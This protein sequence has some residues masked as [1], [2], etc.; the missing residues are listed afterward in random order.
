MNLPIR[1]RLTLAFA[2]AMAVVLA[3]FGWYL[4]LRV[5]S[6]LLRSIDV[7]LRA[8]GEVLLS[9]IEMQEPVPFGQSQVLIDHDEAFAQILDADGSIVETT[10]GA[11]ELPLLPR[12]RLVSVTGPTFV[13]TRIPR[14]DDQARLL[15]VPAS[16]G[17]TPL[18]IV[19]GAD[20]GDRAEALRRL[21]LQLGI[22]GPA[23]LAVAALAG[24]LV[25]G[26]ALR[27]VER[28]RGEAEM[29][30]ASEIQRR[31]E[32]PHT[33]DELARLAATLNAML[34]RLE[35]AL[36][37]EHRFVDDA[38]HELRT[39]LAVLKAELELALSRPRDPDELRAALRAAAAET[40]RLVHLAED[41][42]VLARTRGGRLPL[43]LQ[44]VALREL[45]ES[46]ATAFRVRAEGQ[47]T[48]IEV[49]A[50][51]ETIRADPARLRQAVENLLD[52]ALRHGDGTGPV[53]LSAS[54][55]Q[56]TVVIRVEDGGPGFPAAVLAGAFEPF[57][58]GQSDGIDSR[59]AG[60]GLTIVRAVAEAHGGLAT[61][62]NPEGGGARVSIV[63]RG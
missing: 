23:A 42:L 51:D 21:G 16:R 18:V 46:V 26:A 24:W 31:L 38:S 45:L 5:G 36:E 33:R 56:G 19:V 29:I 52:N 1:A 4:Y 28:I 15:A 3:A 39:P 37:R 11:K 62:E 9:A 12:E 48:A 63:I 44:E 59:G 49:H 27:P 60:L 22:G 53:R 40:D 32:V 30:S 20:M 25:A 8:R 10:P 14:L 57:A 47:G 61:A 54:R 7:N 6:E 41:L 55:E 34:D 13:T 35:E 58:R 17:A 43:R 2:G 50:A